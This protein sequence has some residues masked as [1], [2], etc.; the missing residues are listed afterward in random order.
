VLRF[1]AGGKAL[2][3]DCAGNPKCGWNPAAGLYSC[4]TAGKA[5]PK[6]KHLK[7]CPPS[8]DAGASDLGGDG[9]TPDKAAAAPDQAGSDGPAD[10]DLAWLNEGFV[11]VPDTSLPGDAAALADLGPGELAVGLDA[12]GF[13]GGAGDLGPWKDPV[14]EDEGCSCGVTGGS[15]GWPPLLLLMILL[16]VRSYFRRRLM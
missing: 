7:K 5:D 1:C 9:P 10:P 6:G 11:L 13:E 16:G 2:S 14:D 3:T 4:G 12:T 15:S 8:M